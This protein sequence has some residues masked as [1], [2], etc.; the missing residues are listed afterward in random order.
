MFKVINIHFIYLYSETKGVK[1]LF[2]HM[3]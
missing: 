2:L 1:Q 3:N